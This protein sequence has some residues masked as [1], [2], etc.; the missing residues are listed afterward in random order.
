M[1]MMG[2]FRPTAAVYPTARRPI[3]FG[4]D[5]RT[6]EELAKA[7]VTRQ[8]VGE[9]VPPDKAVDAAIEHESGLKPTEPKAAAEQQRVV[10]GLKALKADPKD[11]AKVVDEIVGKDMDVRDG[12]RG[13]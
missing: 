10:D 6:A 3:Q 1:R 5:K 13:R 9:E 4:A 7:A 2:A 11:A 12:R 8:I